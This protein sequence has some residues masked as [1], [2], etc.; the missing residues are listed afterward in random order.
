MSLSHQD[1]WVSVQSRA[2]QPPNFKLMEIWIKSLKPTSY[3][4]MKHLWDA[5]FC[6]SVE[7]FALLDKLTVF[8]QTK[9]YI[10]MN[11]VWKIRKLAR[12]TWE[13]MCVKETWM[14][15]QLG[16]KSDSCSENHVETVVKTSLGVHVSTSFYAW[17]ARGGGI[18]SLA[19]LC[20]WVKACVFQA[21]V[22]LISLC[23]LWNSKVWYFA[24]R[25]CF[26]F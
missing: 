18:L 13:K 7:S 12:G 8:R 17:V 22:C 2:T 25:T 16:Q 23:H 10:L 14:E 15:K 20:S 21:F 19:N 3:C 11:F 9:S 6:M 1:G 24:G 26:F 4:C 5:W